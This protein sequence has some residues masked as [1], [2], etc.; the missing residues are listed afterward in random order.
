M[1]AAIE[2][3]EGGMLFFLSLP[4]KMDGR[5]GM[6]VA[7]VRLNRLNTARHMKR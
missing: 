6:G 3:K 1:E 7:E 4:E 5:W 2:A